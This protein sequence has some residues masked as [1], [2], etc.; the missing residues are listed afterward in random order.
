MIL[1]GEPPG[2]L[3]FRG[4][5]TGR[6]ESAMIRACPFSGRC[7]RMGLWG[8]D[9]TRRPQ[10]T[11]LITKKS[12][13]GLRL[14]RI[15]WAKATFLECLYIFL[16]IEK[17]VICYGYVIPLGSWKTCFTTTVPIYLY[18]IGDFL[19]RLAGRPSANSNV[20]HIQILNE[21][22]FIHVWWQQ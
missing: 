15:V 12:L 10:S 22:I 6:G 13:R 1:N 20:K 18:R 16:G 19:Q 5:V 8:V 3:W 21:H 11:W 17:N 14:S 7:P 2:T 4:G 9:Q